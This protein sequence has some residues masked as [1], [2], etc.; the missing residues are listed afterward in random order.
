[1]LRR[2]SHI[3]LLAERPRVHEQLVQLLG[4]ARWPAR[5]LMRHPGVID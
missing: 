4:L 2:D 1:M 5:Y 3:A